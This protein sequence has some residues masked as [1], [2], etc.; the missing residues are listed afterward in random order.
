MTKV[1]P[2]QIQEWKAKHGDIFKITVEDK[3]CYLKAPDRKALSYA[4]S[5]GTKDPMKFNEVL[6]KN[7]WLG[8]DDDIKTDDVYF[9]SASQKLAELIQI[10]EAVLEKL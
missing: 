3:E 6:L 4:A 1:T 2:S 8:G 9:L 5:I 10:K 7:C